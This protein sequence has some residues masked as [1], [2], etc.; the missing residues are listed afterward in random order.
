MTGEDDEYALAR[1]CI[2]KPGSL[3]TLTTDL[4][5]MIEGCV[6]SGD[7]VHAEHGRHSLRSGFDLKEEWDA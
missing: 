5:L 2:F 6:S 4:M 3:W 1:R 7:L